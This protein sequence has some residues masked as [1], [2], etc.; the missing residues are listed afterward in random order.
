MYTQTYTCEWG[1]ITWI[2]K[3]ENCP[4]EENIFDFN[5]FTNF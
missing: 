1:W 4:P 3:R 2:N 5:K